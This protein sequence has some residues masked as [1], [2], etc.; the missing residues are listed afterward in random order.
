MYNKGEFVVKATNGIC[1]IVDITTMNLSGENK[2][3]YVLVPIE[4]KGAKVF[5]PV[6]TAENKMRPVMK[7]EE[8]WKL[9]K[10]LNS[11]EEALI[12]NEK[13]R[14]KFYKEAISSC[15]PTC[16]VSILKEL[17]FRRKK[18]LEDGKKTTIVDERYFKLAEK[19]LYSE[20][21]FA[22]GVQKSD[23][24]QMIEKTLK[25]V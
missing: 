15:D 13:D 1:E 8:A 25:L 19:Q 23:I 5:V 17:Y 20:L 16:L 24:N 4:E 2:A 7:K 21:A 10:E 9:I 6:D 22:L 11:V 3:Y 14:E 18:R 12:E